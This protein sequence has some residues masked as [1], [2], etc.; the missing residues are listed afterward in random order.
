MTIEVAEQEF[1]SP[2]RIPWIF[3]FCVP[4]VYRFLK[5]DGISG[6]SSDKGTDFQ[7]HF[8]RKQ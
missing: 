4:N 5:M 2:G 8:L 7:S 3:V 6:K 1:E